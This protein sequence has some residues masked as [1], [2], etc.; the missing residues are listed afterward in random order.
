MTLGTDCSSRSARVRSFSVCLNRSRAVS[1]TALVDPPPEGTST[2]F[3]HLYTKCFQTL[4][5]VVWGGYVR[6]C[7]PSTHNY[8]Q[9]KA[10][11]VEYF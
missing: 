4:F 8:Y 7:P 2:P 3:R 6:V 9:L 11:R 5:R 1:G 10:S